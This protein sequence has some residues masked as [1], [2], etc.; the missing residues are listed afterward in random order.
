MPNPGRHPRARRVVRRRWAGAVGLRPCPAVVARPDARGHQALPLPRPQPADHRRALD[1]RSPAVRRLGSAPGDRL[2]VAA[3]PVVLARRR[4]RT[5]RLD[6]ASAVDRQPVPRRRRRR[7]VARPSLR[8]RRARRVRRGGRVPAVALPAAVRRPHVGDAAAVGRTRLARRPHRAGRHPLEMAPRRTLRPGHRHR[9]RRQR[10]G[11]VDDRSG[12]RALAARRR[13]GT[14]DRL[15]A[16]GRNRRQGRRAVDRR[17]AVVDRR[18]RHPGQAWRGGP[19]LLGIPRG[20]QPHVDLARGVAGARLLADVRPRPI[21]RDD[22]GGSRVPRVGLA[23]RRRLRG[24]RDRPAR[25]DDRAL[26]RASLRRDTRRDGR[27]A[28][29]RGPSVHRSQPADGRALGRW[30]ERP[31]ARRCDRAHAPSPCSSWAWRSAEPR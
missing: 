6:H 17:L 14:P 21:C 5:S 16:G 30:R 24:G 4:R 23:D 10:D 12:A 3:R 28:R 13:C 19:R 29:C 25:P 27:R 26:A 18:R 8:P 31:R 7:A 22:H 9:R 20:R 15:G 1:V 2:P 11:A